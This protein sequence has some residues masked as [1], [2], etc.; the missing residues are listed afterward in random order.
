MIYVKANNDTYVRNNR[1]KVIENRKG[2]FIKF[3]FHSGAKWIY[4]VNEYTA[5]VQAI[6]EQNQKAF[7]DWVAKMHAAQQAAWEKH[8]AKIKANFLKDKI[9]R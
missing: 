9:A 2:E 5:D 8:Q 1:Y 7:H 3:G 4:A 6:D